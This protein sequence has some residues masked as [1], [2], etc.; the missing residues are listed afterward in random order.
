[1]LEAP[2]QSDQLEDYFTSS[3]IGD[4]VEITIAQTEAE[5]KIG[6]DVHLENFYGRGMRYFLMQVLGECPDRDRLLPTADKYD[7]LPDAIRT[8][9]G[10]DL[11]GTIFNRRLG[12]NI[13]P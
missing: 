5:L 12:V 7:V 3:E 4:L 9:F 11:M 10:R 13:A 6:L 2:E 8:R 1:M